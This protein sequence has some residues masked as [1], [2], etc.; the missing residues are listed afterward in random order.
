MTGTTEKDRDPPAAPKAPELPG[1]KE[2][3]GDDK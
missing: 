1:N 2:Q 3:E